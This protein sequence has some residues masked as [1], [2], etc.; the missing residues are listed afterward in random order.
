M[1]Q[2]SRN[3]TSQECKQDSDDRLVGWVVQKPFK[4]FIQAC[5]N[6]EGKGKYLSLATE[7]DKG[8]VFETR[9]SRLVYN[10]SYPKC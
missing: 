1:G 2:R 10:I 7:A 6:E 5:K 3:A 9:P 4:A 8:M